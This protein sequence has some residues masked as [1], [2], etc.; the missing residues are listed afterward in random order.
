MAN[1]GQ[2]RSQPF[3]NRPR[4]VTGGPGA[5]GKGYFSAAEK[6]ICKYKFK[7]RPCWGM[8][9][10]QAALRYQQCDAFSSD[11]TL[12]NTTDARQCPLV[13]S[14][15]GIGRMQLLLAVI[16]NLKVAWQLRVT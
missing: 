7:Y 1:W 14:E 3:H 9:T 12:L 11:S 5:N 8:R 6:L 15:A 10:D 13:K 16:D 2:A 4:A